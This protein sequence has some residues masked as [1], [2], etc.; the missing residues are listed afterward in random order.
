MSDDAAVTAVA[1]PAGWDLVSAAQGG[2]RAAFGLLYAC[3]AGPVSRYVSRRVTDRYLAEDVTAETFVRALRRLDSVSDQ[4]RDVGAWFITIAHHLL[5]DHWK[6]SRHQR[7]TTVAEIPDTASR[8]A[9]PEQVVIDR[10]TA[11]EVRRAVA[12]LTPA[13]QDVIRLRY[14]DE[15]PTAEVAVATGRSTGAVKALQHRG[16]QALRAQL[17]TRAQQVSRWH[18]EAGETS[19]DTD[20]MG[21]AR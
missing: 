4:G 19:A 21:V 15:L 18:T 8:D 17:R 1:R 10:E 5:V 2:D 11:D 16:V 6:S 20:A 12:R 7:D 13:Q 3:Y 14:L 9:S